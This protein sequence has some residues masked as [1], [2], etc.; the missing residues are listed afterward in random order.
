LKI[1]YFEEEIGPDFDNDE[2]N[3]FNNIQINPQFSRSLSF[4]EITSIIFV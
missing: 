3:L 2:L 1:K 4:Q